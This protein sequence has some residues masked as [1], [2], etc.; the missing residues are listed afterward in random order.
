[1]EGSNMKVLTATTALMFLLILPSCRE[2]AAPVEDYAVDIPD[3]TAAPVSESL[4]ETETST[5]P[6]TIMH[7]TAGTDLSF[8]LE[9]NPTTGYHWVLAGIEQDSEVVEQSG[10]AVYTPSPNPD[11]MVG[12]GGMEEWTF[13]TLSA[14][15]ALIKLDYMP[16]GADREP[17]T[18]WS[19]KVVVE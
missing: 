9:A 4:V 15:E 19:A 6:D 18:V 13:A 5:E 1:M 3:A 7:V 2:E 12:A 11:G 10:E 14:G 16:P 8:T 17:G